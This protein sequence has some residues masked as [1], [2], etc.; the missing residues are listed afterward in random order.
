MT[1]SITINPKSN[2]EKIK[3]YEQNNI[4]QEMLTQT[5]NCNQILVQI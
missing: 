3:F 2:L 4:V 1:F 5:I